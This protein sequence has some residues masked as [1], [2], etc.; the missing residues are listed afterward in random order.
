[1]KGK[2]RQGR[3]SQTEFEQEPTKEKRNNQDT[4]KHS[5]R[6]NALLLGI[7]F[8]MLVVWEMANRLFHVPAYLLPPP[9]AIARS[10]VENPGQ[11][12][13]NFI[14][15]LQEVLVGFCIGVV[16]SL[17]LGALIV[18]ISFFERLIYPALVAFQAIPKV[19]LAPILVVW[20]GFGPTSKIMLGFVSA[21]FPIVVNTVIGL[22]QTHPEMIYLMRS[23]GASS[24]QIFLKIRLLTA[25]PYIFGGFKVGITLAVVGAVVGEFIAANSGLGYMLLVANNSFKI[26]EMFSVVVILSLMSIGL[27]YLIE[28]IEVILLPKPLRRKGNTLETGAKT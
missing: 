21:M 14:T 3:T 11:L 20:F 9:S 7:Y 18:S 2:M 6:T 4:R 16:V 5:L 8:A 13:G 24:L 19:A 22:K 28:L 12:L 27:Y 1:M 26:T 15:T 10:I 25:A 23:L 17:A